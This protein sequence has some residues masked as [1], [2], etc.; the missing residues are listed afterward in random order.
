MAGSTAIDL[1]GQRFGR[2]LALSRTAN[3][4]TGLTAWLCR[5]DCGSDRV[6]PTT[7]LR[8]GDTRSCGCL[9]REL[10]GLNGKLS[11]TTHGQASNPTLTYNSW[12]AMKQRC[13]NPK[14]PNYHKYGALGITVDPMWV[15]SFEAFFKHMGERPPG[16][17]LDRI[18]ST[19]NYEPG[20][21]R[22]AT[23]ME[24]RHNRKASSSSSE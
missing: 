12:N 24:Q 23:P 14:A 6:V 19:G 17:S 13:L 20:N 3:T 18:D 22:W 9:P 1:T 10:Y 7:Y 15:T 16:T 4:T 11:S 8:T 21:C 2:L 5:C